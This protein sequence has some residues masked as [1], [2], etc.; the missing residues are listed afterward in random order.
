MLGTK[1]I[2][3]ISEN[4]MLALVED[5]SAKNEKRYSKVIANVDIAM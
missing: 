5:R 1:N 4:T 3:L 2:F